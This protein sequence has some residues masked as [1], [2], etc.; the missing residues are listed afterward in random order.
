[1]ATNLLYPARFSPFSH[2]MCGDVSTGGGGGSSD[3][4]GWAIKGSND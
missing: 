1:M 4:V 2:Q 3:Q